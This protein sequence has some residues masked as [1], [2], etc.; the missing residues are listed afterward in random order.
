MASPFLQ[1][2]AF[3]I[4]E[5][6]PGLY[7]RVDLAR[8]G[9]A[10]TTMRNAYVRYQGGASSRAGTKFVGFSKQ[11]G[12]DYPPRLVTFQFNVNQGL[13]LEFGHQYM[14]VIQNGAFV[15]ET[16]FPLTNITRASPAV[17]TTGPN[18]GATAATANTGSVSASYVPTELVTLAGGTFTDPTVL[19]VTNT[20][21][22]SLSVYEGGTGYVPTNTITLAGGTQ[23]T[24]PVVTVNTTEVVDVTA[25]AAP[26]AG[27]TPG[28]VVLTGTTGTGTMFQATGVISGGGL[29][30]QVDAIILNGSY[31]VNPTSL[32]AEP[33]TGGGLVGAQLSIAMGVSTVTVTNAGVF[34]TNAAGGAFTQ[35]SSSGAGTGATF[36]SA[37]FAPNAMAV[38]RVGS[39][40]A[41]PANPVAQDTTTGGG[42]GATFT[43]T[44]G[45]ASPFSDGDWV[46]LAS[47]Q[48]MTEVNGETYV[49][50]NPS[51]T[52][53]ELY[54]VYGSP[55]DSSGFAAYIAGGTAAR[56]YTLETPYH[57]QDISYLKFIQN[58][59]VMSLCLVNQVTL[60]EYPPLDLARNSNT[61]WE[62]ESVIAGATIAAPSTMS[63]VASSSGSTN[64]QYVVTAVDPD[65]GTESIAS[66]IASISSAVNIAATAGSITLTW[67][68]VPGVKQYNV[69]KATPGTGANIPVGALFGF[70]GSAYGTQ[71]IDSNII[72]DFSQVPPKHKEP[73]AR[74][75]ILGVDV[76]AGGAGY[77]SITLTAVSAT[78][79]GASLVGVLVGGALSAVIVD[80]PGKNYLATDTIS[81]TG[82]GGA[83]ATATLDVGPQTGTY[84]GA[85]GYF[86]QRRV[87]GNTINQPDTYFMSQPAAYTNFDSRIP[88]I[89]T[90][91][92]VGNPWATQVN[93]IQQMLQMPGGLV[94]LT[95]LAAWQLTGNGGSS[96]NPQPITPSSQDA[97]PQ[98]FNGCHDNIPA[99]KIDYDI[100]YVQQ[101]GSIVRNFSYQYYQNIYTGADLTLNSSHMFTNY[102]MREWAWCEEP[103]KTVWVVRDDGAM[104]SLTYVKPQEVAG[105]ARH[106]TNGLFK[107]VCSVTEPPVDALYL[108][109]ERFP[110]DNTCYTIE[111]MDNRIWP[112]VEDVWCVDCGARLAQNTPDAI[113]TASSATGLGAISGFSDLVGGTGYSAGTTARII[114][115]KNDGS[116]PENPPSGSGAVISLTIVGGVITAVNVDA[117]G[118]GYTYPALVIE[119]PA[120]SGSGASATPTLDNSATFEASGAVFDTSVVG[121][122][123]RMGGGVATVTARTSTTEVVAQI[124]SPITLLI[125]NT[126]DPMPAASGDWTLT[127]PAS[128]VGGLTYLAGA[129]VTGTYD[130]KVLPPTVVPAT[131]R[132]DLPAP[133]TAVTVGLGFGVQ[134]QSTYLNTQGGTTAQGQRKAIEG[135]TVRM[136]SSRGITVGSN[137]PDGAALSPPRL[138]PQWTGMNALPDLARPAYGSDLIPLYTG[139]AY[140][141]ITGGFGDTGQVA[142]EQLE[143]LPMTCLAFVPVVLE[144]DQ[145]EGDPKAQ[146]GNR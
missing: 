27:G 50:R 36:R 46:Q 113:L 53:F 19:R 22:K 142:V 78:G 99:I 118:T 133:A 32:A 15:T 140:I 124:T 10:A 59:D 115:D 42:E 108:A 58:K 105:W 126:D 116:D 139:D 90:D 70:A 51:A 91:A 45:A 96:F 62:F 71:F 75:A 130:G 89:D 98:A 73:F 63:G 4:G 146:R 112:T 11:T 43:V 141:P 13:A 7:G 122:V 28:A 54:D 16:A 23:T 9:V 55:I 136:E 72:A 33:V 135:V 95:G 21:I 144:G 18:I 29:L 102:Q 24:A 114:D 138:A 56:I 100:L 60:V 74:G 134:L 69:Y 85:P 64:Y 125:P 86:Q 137:Q 41:Y 106:D 121:S 143:P 31:T 66:P 39:Y 145:P 38:A 37:I 17:V 128:S 80:N 127:A 123:I 2:P 117:P 25:I 83:G 132:I 12:R 107:S 35:A 26:G 77:T 92:I 93:G 81:V 49:V 65:N 87:Y 110:G 52:T 120:G 82:A 76:G 61:D 8:F 34:T 111:R 44:S 57:E 30:I 40:S 6:A 104:L 84:P 48:G 131:G 47:V 5:L 97:Q 129:T 103:Y 14:R 68:A 1:N 67:S 3:T 20:K 88:T 94:V 109:V 119:D 101:K 79:S